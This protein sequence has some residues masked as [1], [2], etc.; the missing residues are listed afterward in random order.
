MRL[1]LLSQWSF[2]ARKYILTSAAALKI[3][4]FF[5]LFVGGGGG[6]VVFMYT[7]A[8]VQRYGEALASRCALNV[9]LIII[10]IIIIKMHRKN[11]SK[12][13]E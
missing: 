9:L 11:E 4:F 6:G 12:N 3:F 8:L 2:P 5:F 13:T 1:G 10:I 7:L